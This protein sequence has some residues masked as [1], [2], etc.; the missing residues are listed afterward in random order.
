MA[1]T[2]HWRAWFEEFWGHAFGLGQRWWYAMLHSQEFSAK[3]VHVARGKSLDWTFRNSKHCLHAWSS[4]RFPEASNNL[5][6]IVW[7]VADVIIASTENRVM[8]ELCDLGP[9]RGPSVLVYG[10]GWGNKD[11]FASTSSRALCW[12]DKPTYQC[13]VCSHF[14]LI[15]QKQL[16]CKFR[17]H[18]VTNSTD[19]LMLWFSGYFH[20]ISLLLNF[21]SVIEKIKWHDYISCFKNIIVLQY[22]CFQTIWEYSGFVGW[23]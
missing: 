18:T 9:Y 2:P 1:V 21:S 8:T 12:Q 10:R 4:G 14:S 11:V 15:R 23:K 6:E 20:F 5:G 17:K 13:W 7:H 19:H 22:F 3:V 16:P